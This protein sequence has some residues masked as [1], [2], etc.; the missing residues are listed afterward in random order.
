V[1]KKILALFGA[2]VLML[3]IGISGS[4]SAAAAPQNCNGHILVSANYVRDNAGVV[5]GAIQLCRERDK[6]FWFAMF[7]YYGNPVPTGHIGTARLFQ[8]LDTGGAAEASNCA[9]GTGNASGTRTW[10]STLLT[11]TGTTLYRARGELLSNRTGNWVK[12]A[13]GYTL[14]CSIHGCVKG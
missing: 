8:R 12:Y 4:V 13:E 3:G 1:L 7:F 10:C 5:H 6:N 14:L 11:F 2:L 9:E